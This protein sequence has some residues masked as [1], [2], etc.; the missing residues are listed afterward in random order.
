MYWWQLVN[1][2]EDEMLSK[3]YNAQRNNPVKDDWTTQ[4]D[5]YKL[6]LNI[7]LNDEDIKGISR[8]KFKK[9]LKTKIKM[10]TLAY[11]NKLKKKHI[12]SN[13]STSNCTPYNHSRAVQSSGTEG[14]NY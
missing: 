2:N 12:K 7:N 3:F 9:Y 14:H 13:I 8:Y 11:L 10:A 4:I 6:E 5:K 1:T